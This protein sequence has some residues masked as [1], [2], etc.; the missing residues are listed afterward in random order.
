MGKLQKRDY[1]GIGIGALILIVVILLVVPVGAW[2]P[3]TPKAYVKVTA[4]IT[5]ELF[6]CWFNEDVSLQYSTD[7]PLASTVPR[8][9]WYCGWGA[10]TPPPI[11]TT[12]TVE[13]PDYSIKTY[14]ESK[15]TCEDRPVEFFRTVPLDRGLGT[16]KVTAVVCG[17]T[18]WGYNCITKTTE[19]YGGQ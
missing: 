2:N 14:S 7:N 12:L 17:D 1:A 5:C 6:Y 18:F 15:S 8:L 9:A 10:G 13:C 3:F 16:Y 19:I 4:G 11:E